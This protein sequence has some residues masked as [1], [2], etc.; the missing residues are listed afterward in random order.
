MS[1]EKAAVSQLPC[2]V[3]GVARGLGGTCI[4]VDASG[5]G[6]SNWLFFFLIL[7]FVILM[8]CI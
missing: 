1:G 7:L 5:K 8:Q 2:L 4:P 3:G 6:S